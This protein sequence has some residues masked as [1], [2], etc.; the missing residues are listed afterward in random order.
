V[1]ETKKFDPKAL[2]NLGLTKA[3]TSQQPLA[4]ANVVRLRRLHPEKSP[5]QL[6]AYLN[7]FY[8]GAVTATGAGAGAAALLPNGVVQV[9]VALADLLTFLEASVFY[10][11]SVAEI[12][13]L[14]LEDVERRRLLVISV[15][16]GDSVA[17]SVLQPL[18]GRTGPYWGKKIVAAIP[19]TVINAANKVLGPRFITKYGVKQ[20]VVVLGA[21]VPLFIGVAIGAGGNHVFGRF[22]IKAAK[23]ILGPAPDLW[24][25]P[26]EHDSLDSSGT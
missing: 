23:T 24:G 10:T 15:L 17:S 21:Q 2:L 12:H 9:P 19:M 18:I 16:V 20:G 1:T 14:D 11:L 3:L 6:I 4:I 26:V 8:L 7:K 5:A 13:Q 22:I 25:D